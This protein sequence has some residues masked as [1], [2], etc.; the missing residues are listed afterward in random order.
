MKLKQYKHTE[1]NTDDQWNDI[2]GVF[3]VQGPSLDFA[4]LDKWASLFKVKDLLENASI[5]AGLDGEKNEAKC[6]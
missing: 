3:K 4:Y 1:K 6:R 2:L 5:D